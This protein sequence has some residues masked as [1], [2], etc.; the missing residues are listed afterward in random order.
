MNDIRFAFRQLLKFRDS[1]SRSSSRWRWA[2][3]H[4][5]IFSLVHAVLMKSLPV[6][7][8]KTLYRI[9]DKDDCC[10]SGGYLNDE[11]DSNSFP[12]SCISIFATPQPV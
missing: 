2:L 6:I 1:H 12:T 7:D 3:A 4:T 11:G 5:A 8:P 9:G 10:V